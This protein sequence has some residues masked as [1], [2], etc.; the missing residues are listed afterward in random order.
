M[1]QSDS[2]DHQDSGTTQTPPDALTASD[3]I[4]L[5]T[6]TTGSDHYHSRIHNQVAVITHHGVERS[7]DLTDR[8]LA[9]WIAYVDTKRGWATIN[10][11]ESFGEILRDALEES[12]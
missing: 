5:G 2:P 8:T 7:V 10:Y 1:S 4:H 6:D 9:S 11:R 12:R 3:T